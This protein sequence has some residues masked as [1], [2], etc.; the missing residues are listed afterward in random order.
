MDVTVLNRLYALALDELILPTNTLGGQHAIAAIQRKPA[1]TYSVHEFDPGQG[2]LRHWE[3]FKPEY[4]PGDLFDSTM[5]LFDDIAE[6]LVLPD[7]D[8]NGAV[9]I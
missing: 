1:F 6:I 2:G 4:W 9:Y 5:I 7:L 8:L 3:Q